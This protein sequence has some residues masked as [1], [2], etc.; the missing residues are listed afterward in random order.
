MKK[1]FIT[2]ASFLLLSLV[3][4]VATLL[5]SYSSSGNSVLKNYIEST[6]EEEIGLPVDVKKF[7]LESDKVK[8]LMHINSQI[9]VEVVSHYNLWEY[10]FEGIYRIKTKGFNYNSLHLRQMNIKGNFKGIVKNFTVEGN[11]TI[12][13]APLSYKLL[14]VE[15]KVQNIKAK[16]KGI[17]LSEVL[18]LVGEQNIVTG[19]ID[20]D[21]NMPDIGKVTAKGYGHIT[22]K[23]GMFNRALVKKLYNYTLP[24]GSYVSANMDAKLV[25]QS[26]AF[27]MLAKSNLFTVNVKEGN[28]NLR[29][30]ETK[31]LAIKAKY[32]VDVKDLRILSEN[33]L[34]GPI[35]VKGRLVL[36]DENI[37][38][39]G[40]SR[41]LGGK[42]HFDVTEKIELHLEKLA[43]EKI[44]MLVR[45]PIYAKGIVSGEIDLEKTMQKGQYHLAIK[46]G[47]F[48]VKQIGKDTGYALPSKDTFTLLSKGAVNKQVLE[49][50]LKLRSTALEVDLAKMQYVFKRQKAQSD[51]SIKV[52]DV[53]L[54][55]A[56]S[57]VTKHD[58][59]QVQGHLKYDTSLTIDGT[60]SGLAKK[61]QFHYDSK[62]TTFDAK[63]LMLQKVLTLSGL[64][65][66]VDGDIDAYVK[67]DNMKRLDGTFSI[68]GKNITTK[69]K[70]MQKLLGK[71]LNMKLNIK[72]EGKIKKGMVTANST[73]KTD[74]A[75]VVL[76]H[77]TMNIKTK[78]LKSDYTLDIPNM[79]KLYPLTETKL[80]GKMYIK[81]HLLY[82][83]LLHA[84]GETRSLGGEINY[85]L[86]KNQL[87]SKVNAV[88]IE[89]MMGMMGISQTVLGKASGIIKY[90]LKYKKGVADI[91]IRSFQIKPNKT[92]NTFKIF[93]GKDP[94]RIIFKTTKVH[95]TM[96]DDITTYSL[97]AKGTRAFIDITQGILNKK[98]QANSAKFKF[99]YEKYVINGVI[100]G[101][102]DNPKIVI[103]PTS[104]I[105]TKVGD[106]IGK[107][108]DKVFKSKMGGFLK[109]LKF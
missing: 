25:G 104:M 10:S 105:N 23:N 39:H 71:A 49:A 41:S 62:N 30:E 95:A 47:K 3:L 12:L 37:D 90:N 29:Q 16:M 108:L 1:L 51:Y 9:D 32:A 42:F 87:I 67:V 57:K 64:P 33:K 46:E 82:D 75:N 22:L 77:M 14:V 45:Q 73:L 50:E 13:D 99:V 44:L 97:H 100:N 68:Q 66:Y 55:M 56:N 26:V 107:G 84:T 38:L 98:T 43:L 36:S 106:E 69:P 58:V 6:I 81:G 48:N 8:L 63:T 24:K 40:E 85:T 101:T 54:L 80:Y 17:S 109:G 89:K 65:Q 103:D 5:F 96:N 86:E 11:G 20:I 52:H 28:I 102:V 91:L 94:A 4:I 35:L 93:I 21:I 53:G 18:T 79:Q 34:S 61:L 72:S 78:I 27:A 92:T 60:A 7:T 19:K 76:S 31:S 2:L 88:P 70:E 15:S 74:I 83:T 59:M